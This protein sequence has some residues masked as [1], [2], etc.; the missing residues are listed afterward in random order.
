MENKNAIAFTVTGDHIQLT[1]TALASLCKNHTTDEHLDVLIVADGINPADIEWI[2]R[3]P[4][5]YHQENVFVTVWEPPAVV[6]QIT[7]SN[8]SAR[9][10]GMTYWRL[11]LPAYFPQFTRL[12]YVDNDVLFYGDVSAIFLKVPDDRPVAAVPDFYY[13]AMPN[14]QGLADQFRLA[15]SRD[16]VNAGV[17]LYNVPV[18]NEQFPVA[19]VLDA[20]NANHFKYHD[21]SVL[22]QLTADTIVRLPLV[23]NYQKDDH[24]LNDWAKVNATDQYPHFAKAHDHVL[25]RHFVEFAQ[26]SMPWE[27]L[28]INDPWEADWWTTLQSLKTRIGAFQRNA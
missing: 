28:A 18:F 21:Q 13:H 9:F 22:N 26:Y 23:Y 11:F 16:Y 7:T 15:S 24:W 19:T 4:A 12:L 10:P 14:D 5:L 6:G 8:T 17:I 1:A 27:H 25:I 20:V 2:R 3:I